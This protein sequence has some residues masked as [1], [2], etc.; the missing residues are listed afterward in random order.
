MHDVA[1]MAKGQFDA[2]LTFVTTSH[3]LRLD[4]RIR[5][6]VQARVKY[7]FFI[8]LNVYSY[9]RCLSYNP[10]SAILCHN[11]QS[12]NSRTQLTILDALSR[13]S[14]ARPRRNGI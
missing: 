13:S 6:A 12:Q 5:P 7:C 3:V 11:M 2:S 9:Q 4:G 14:E 1:A 10:F 8:S